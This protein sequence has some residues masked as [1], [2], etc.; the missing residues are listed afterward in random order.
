METVFLFC[1]IIG[2]TVFVFQFVMALFGLGVEHAGLGDFSH[3]ISPDAGHHGLAD[4]GSTSLFA[5]ISV[6]TLVAAV[7]FFGLAG[8][9]SMEA[10]QGARTSVLV[11]VAAGA[12][13]MYSVHWLM[14]LVFRMGQ[15]NTVR[16][17]R[18]VGLRATVYVPIPPRS[19]GAGKIHLKLQ[20]RIV[21]Y[22]AMTDEPEKLR[23]G[24][25]VIV[26][27]VVSSNT[28]K[29]ELVREPVAESG[30]PQSIS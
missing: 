10:G 7:T 6:R 2:G 12:A 4:H 18:S 11:G 26:V 25:R 3:D 20:N 30:T 13:A 14:M 22:Q 19:S 1:A 16:I 8:L 23:T 29:V 15:D 24:T 28:V 17:E 21:E 5:V 9:A 27:D